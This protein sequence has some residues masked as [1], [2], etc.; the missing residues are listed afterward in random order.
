MKDLRGPQPKKI[1]HRIFKHLIEPNSSPGFLG[2]IVRSVLNQIKKVCFNTLPPPR[3]ALT[4]AVKRSTM[5]PCFVP[6]QVWYIIN[7]ALKGPWITVKKGETILKYVFKDM[8]ALL[9]VVDKGDVAA[10]FRGNPQA[11]EDKDCN[12]TVKIMCSECRPVTLRYSKKT[13]TFAWSFYA[14]MC[15]GH[16][17]VM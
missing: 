7:K 17:H 10:I 15:D 11:P 3:K 12:R 14:L 8:S 4:G 6:K 9:R 2:A 13:Q 16:G 1:T 5:P